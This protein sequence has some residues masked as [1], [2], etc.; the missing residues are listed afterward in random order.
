MNIAVVNAGTEPTVTRKESKTV[1]VGTTDVVGTSINYGANFYPHLNMQLITDTNLR[2]MISETNRCLFLTLGFGIGISPFILQES[3]R[4]Q[5]TIILAIV[6]RIIN[7]DKKNPSIEGYSAYPVQ[8]FLHSALAKGGFADSKM[9]TFLWPYANG[10]PMALR[11][12]VIHIQ[13]ENYGKTGAHLTLFQTSSCDGSR[14]ELIVILENDHYKQFQGKLKI[15][16]ILA[17]GSHN[18]VYDNCFNYMEK[19]EEHRLQQEALQRRQALEQ[20]AQRQK[21]AQ[22]HKEAKR[23]KNAQLTHQS[24]EERIQQEQ[25][26]AEEECMERS[27]CTETEQPRKRKGEATADIRRNEALLSNEPSL[28][29]GPSSPRK[30]SSGSPV[31]VSLSGKSDPPVSSGSLGKC[32]FAMIR[33]S[34]SRAVYSFALLHK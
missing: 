29:A 5:A 20:H 6:D 17:L 13:K 34:D 9:L 4:Q 8:D 10:K 21:E 32:L 16:Q 18:T 19:Q 28:S 33:Q 25:K 24:N 23:Q 31:A 30:N 26:E 12:L 1:R 11:I 22:R 27:S 3:M 2:K 7:G 14:K 15:D